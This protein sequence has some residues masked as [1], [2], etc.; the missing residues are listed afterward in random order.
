MN[1]DFEIVYCVPIGRKVGLFRSSVEFPVRVVGE[2][3]RA[4]GECFLRTEDE[5]C[6][7][8]VKRPTKP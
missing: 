5:Y 2:L 8:E 1:W 6:T 4:E 7:H 3:A